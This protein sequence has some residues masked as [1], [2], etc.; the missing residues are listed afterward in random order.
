VARYGLNFFLGQFTV[1]IPVDN[2]IPIKEDF[3]LSS[4]TKAYSDIRYPQDTVPKDT[5]VLLKGENYNSP[6]AS[7][8][9][10][11]NLDSSYKTHE[12]RFQIGSSTLYMKVLAGSKPDSIKVRFDTSSFLSVSA[13]S[14]APSA[15][16]F[17]KISL[18]FDKNFVIVHG[19][20]NGKIS[21]YDVSGKRLFSSVFSSTNA[22]ISMP[23]LS[24]ARIFVVR[25]E[26]EG[27]E[28]FLKKCFLN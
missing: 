17:Q 20:A 13:I 19:I 6:C 24:G 26:A 1:P 4:G 27:Q 18:G 12:Y 15:Q 7:C 28:M 23:N 22:R 5:S 8:T 16:N 11:V 10:Y 3:Y 25:V 2:S 21:F 9:P 14:L